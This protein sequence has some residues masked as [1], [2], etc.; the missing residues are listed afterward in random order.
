MRFRYKLLL[1]VGG[2]GAIVAA[3]FVLV[4]LATKPLDVGAREQFSKEF[5]C[6]EERIQVRARPDVSAFDVYF[7]WRRPEPPETPAVPRARRTRAWSR[8]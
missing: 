8:A 5:S 6:P 7:A 3:P 4:A 2:L 1:S